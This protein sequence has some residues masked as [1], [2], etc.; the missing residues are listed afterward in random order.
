MTPTTRRL[1]LLLAGAAS[2]F[3][4]MAAGLGRLGWPDPGMTIM[5]VH[6]PLMICGFF[7]TVIGLERAVA[8][9]KT[10]GYGAPLATALGG[11]Y[12]VAGQTSTGGLLLG[13]GSLIFVLMSLAVLR[14][15]KEDFTAVLGL[16]AL[17]WLMGNIVWLI[18]GS[19]LDAVPLWA[20]FLVLTIAGE[21]LELSRFLPPWRWRLPSLV[22]VLALL[23][24]GAGAAAAEHHLAWPLFGCGL[25]AMTL[26]CLRNDVARR[27]I[28]QPG[29]TRYVAVC[30]LS[31]YAWA[32][33]SG[34]LMLGLSL[35]EGGVR[36]DAA[37]HSLFV[38]F[39]FSMVFGHAPVILPAVLRV[40]VPYKSY[41]YGPLA[42]LHASLALRLVGDLAEL[43][44]IRQWGGLANATAII[45]FILSM[46]VTVLRARRPRS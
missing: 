19:P 29:L 28:R 3:V 36:A 40:A 38:G 18:R 8:L 2:L 14:R 44:E 46:L 25:V 9:G 17:S 12:L 27:T 32:A 13:L 1:P 21:R 33:V 10:W 42:L 23:L 16:G 4:G 41:F 37:F 24:A 35:D 7:G 11:F 5:A 15:Q 20:G 45:V 31:G 22:P 6:G 43:H 26:W 30:L 39:V 34:L